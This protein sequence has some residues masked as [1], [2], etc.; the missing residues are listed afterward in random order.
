MKSFITHF[1]MD[2]KGGLRDKTLLLMNYLFPLG[3]YLV[4]GGIMPKLNPQYGDILI[5]SMMIFGILVSA[6]LGMP[7]V[8]VTSRNN[9]IFRSY[10][11]N[12][13]SK[14]SMLAIPTLSTVFHTIIVTAIILLSA[15]VL[16]GAKLP[17]NIGGLILVFLATVIVCTG[18]ALL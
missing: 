11:I 13:V 15:P 2:L 18:I 5:P 6:I 9:G 3:F 12:G 14:L 7:N 8:L 4:M 10:K 17:G 1:V 16:F